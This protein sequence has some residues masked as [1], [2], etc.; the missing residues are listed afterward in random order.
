LAPPLREI[1]LIKKISPVRDSRP[2]GKVRSA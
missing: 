2:P 1:F